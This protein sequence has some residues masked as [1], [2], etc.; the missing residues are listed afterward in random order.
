ML[1]RHLIGI[2]HIQQTENGGLIV[3]IAGERIVN[4]FKFYA[5][6]QENEE[7]TVRCGSEELGTIVLPPPPGEKIAIAG[8]VWIVE[9]VDRKRHLVYCE[10]VRGSVPAYFG[11]C[12]G[13]INTKVLE[14]MRKALAEDKSYP[15]LMKNAVVRLA[16]AR[17]TAANSGAAHDPLIC[18]RRSTLRS[19]FDIL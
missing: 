11:D 3:G 1:L 17:H 15:Y 2:E 19:S 9:E 18:L 12:P 7:F 16:E 13:D 14:R 4:N 8:H 5:V 10:Q 6:F